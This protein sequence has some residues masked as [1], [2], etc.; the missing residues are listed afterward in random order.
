MIPNFLLTEQNITEKFLVKFI[1]KRKLY[2]CLTLKFGF[3][4]SLNKTTTTT[5][6]T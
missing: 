3:I 1:V 2:F 4:K 6:T 5:T